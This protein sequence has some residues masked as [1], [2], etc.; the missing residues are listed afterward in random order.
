MKVQNIRMGV[1]EEQPNEIQAEHVELLPNNNLAVMTMV[2]IGSDRQSESW[3]CSTMDS[4]YEQ[5]R[6][7]HPQLVPGRRHTIMKTKVGANWRV[8]E[9]YG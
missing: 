8:E 7:R 1:V 2:C 3:V 9:F 5:L 6:E 4:A